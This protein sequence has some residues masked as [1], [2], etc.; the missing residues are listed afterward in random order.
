MRISK[1]L[2]ISM[3][4]VLSVLS[5]CY[6]DDRVSLGFLYGST[7]NID[8]IDRTNGG[9]NQVSPTCL[10][11]T[12]SGKLLVTSNLTHEFV[13]KMHERNIKVTPFLSNHWARQKGRNAVNNAEVLSDQIVETIIEYELDGVNVDIENLTVED[14]D[15]L[16]E[17]VRILKEK[18]PEGTI[19]SVSVAANPNDSLTGWQGSYDY[20][21]LG[22]YADYLFIMSYDEHGIGSPQGPVSSTYFYEKSILTALK[23]VSKDKIVMG[24]PFF[25]RYW[26]LDE[27]TG[28]YNGGDAVVI[29]AMPS[30][31]D[32][33]KGKYEYNELVGEASYTFTITDESDP[34]TINGTTLTNGTYVIWYQTNDSIRDKLW[35]INFYDLLGSGVWAL[36]QEKV[37]VWDYYYRRLNEK[38]R[39]PEEQIMLALLEEE[40]VSASDRIDFDFINEQILKERNTLTEMNVTNTVEL[41]NQ[42][43]EMAHKPEK[44]YEKVSFKKTIEYIQRRVIRKKEDDTIDNNNNDHIFRM[45]A[46]Y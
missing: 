14:R 21:M 5:T 1:I 13:N 25:G 18:M 28:E 30:I 43:D 15:A 44:K 17:F 8:L 45:E 35:L 3:L 41:N 10:D 26:K 27:E 7:S 32:K 46:N 38:E 2:V 36:G 34:I 6:A 42:I 37:E 33:V 31:M 22:E 29:G 16:S 12:D 4:I 23:H 40:N 9:L 20:D 19:L 24:I 11:L 39:I